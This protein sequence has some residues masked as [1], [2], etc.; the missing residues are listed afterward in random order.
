MTGQCH[1]FPETDVSQPKRRGALRL[2][3]SEGSSRRRRRSS[4]AH[5]RNSQQS[6][7]QSKAQAKKWAQ[8]QAKAKKRA[9]AKRWAQAQAKAKKTAQAKKRAAKAKKRAEECKE[10]GNFCGTTGEEVTEF[11][12]YK[13]KQVQKD[14][15]ISKCYPQSSHHVYNKMV[16]LC[17]HSFTSQC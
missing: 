13:H 2:G 7:P 6:T 11:L 9:Q 17:M 1:K 15:C 4:T 14:A 16:T 3:E 8:T 5:H 10:K 12:A